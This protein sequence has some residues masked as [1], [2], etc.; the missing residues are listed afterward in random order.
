[1]LKRSRKSDKLIESNI[2]HNTNYM[3][4]LFSALGG[5]HQ[6]CI[7]LLSLNNMT[8][9]VVKSFITQLEFPSV[10]NG[11]DNQDSK[12]FLP[13]LLNYKKYKIKLCSIQIIIA[14]N[15]L[16]FFFGRY[17]NAKSKNPILNPHPP[18]P[19]KKI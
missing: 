11:R 19:Q 5:P 8:I 3:F 15:I 2:S 17:K 7:A 14:I 10:F 4:K 9:S 18:P 13:Q 12:C 16:I 6:L 1:M